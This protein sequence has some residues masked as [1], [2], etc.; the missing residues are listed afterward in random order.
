MRPVA[1]NT[2]SIEAE[3]T[4]IFN[5]IG[6]PFGTR[7]DAQKAKVGDLGVQRSYFSVFFRIG[8]CIDFSIDFGTP[9]VS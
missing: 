9:G 2:F 4:L 3:K 7:N 1:K 6:H 5:S 8:F